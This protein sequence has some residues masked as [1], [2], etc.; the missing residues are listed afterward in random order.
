MTGHQEVAAGTAPCLACRFVG[1]A[2]EPVAAAE[3]AAAAAAAADERA[4]AAAAGMAAAAVAAAQKAAAAG[5]GWHCTAFGRPAAAAGHC[6]HGGHPVADLHRQRVGLPSVGLCQS[7]HN[8][9]AAGSFLHCNT[10]W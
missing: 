2:W 5:M 6:E 3:R 1:K 4:A 9:Q 7:S 10:G 8:S